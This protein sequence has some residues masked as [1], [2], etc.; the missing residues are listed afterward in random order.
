MYRP[1]HQGWVLR[2]APDGSAGVPA[3]VRAR[4][5]P[6]SVPGCVH[7]DLLAAG[8]IPD[9]YLDDNEVR[10]GWIGRADWE[11]ET[12][13]SWADDVPW[14]DDGGSQVDL[15]CA[16]LDTVA[17]VTLNGVQLGQ[18]ANMHRGYSFPVR[19]LLRE[20][21]NRLRVR[22]DS[23]YRYA[24][25][26]VEQLGPRPNEYPE[27]FNFIRKMACNF[28]WDWGPNLV[29]AGIWRPIGLRSWRI[30]RLAQV[31]PL[32]SMDSVTVHIDLERAPTAPGE[33]LSVSAAVAGVRGEVT[34]A[35][36]D[37]TAVVH[38]SVPDPELWWPRGYGEQHR[39]LLD[40]T[41]RGPDGT[42]LDTWQRRIGFR[43][44]RV[45]TTPDADGTPF[46]LVVNE[47]PVFVRGA[48]WIPDDA[49]TG[50]TGSGTRSG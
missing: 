15:V 23:A 20:G 26:L 4:P 17:T 29:T 38:L 25:R 22:F 3:E 19:H 34:V 36:G 37:R 31:R 27:P 21:Q 50:W 9:P 35:P 12:Q 46:T 14:T 24:Q 44:V 2:P 30:A 16:G 11:Y 42:V 6:A 5:V 28:G 49:F 41:L 40:V 1:L 32:T 45:D 39:Y 8:L 47:V 43:S 10:L 13:F 48:N 33:R 18:T 7:T